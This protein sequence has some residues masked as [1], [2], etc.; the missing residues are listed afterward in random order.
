MFLLKGS[1]KIII[2]PN[3]YIVFLC[4][5]HYFESFVFVDL[6]N[7]PNSMRSILFVIA[8]APL[9]RLNGREFQGFIHAHGACQW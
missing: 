8:I 6:F 4:T 9:R 1:M 2:I 5:R 7:S 3:T